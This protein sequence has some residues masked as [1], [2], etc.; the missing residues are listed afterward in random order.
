MFSSKRL[1]GRRSYRYSVRF[2]CCSFFLTAAC[3]TLFSVIHFIYTAP[4]AANAYLYR[5]QIHMAM[6]NREAVI[7]HPVDV[8]NYIPSDFHVYKNETCPERF[9]EM[10][11]PVDVNMTEISLKQVESELKH[12]I[13]F[14]G[15]WKPDD[16]IPK[17]RVAFLIPF[18]NRHQHVPILLRH[19]FPHLFK[20]H[21]EF[22]IFV[23]N[24]EGDFPF[25]RA[26]LLNIGFVEIQKLKKDY[27]DCFI[28]HDVDHIPENDRIYY[29]CKDM[30]KHF[31]EQLDIHLYRLEYD[32]FFGG[33]SGVMT[34]QFEKVNGFCN[35]FWGWGG[36]DDDFYARI[37]H[38]GYN[39]SRPPN[40][41]GRYQ[42]IVKHHTQEAQ[43]L[44][45]F[46]LLHDSVERSK[47][48]GLNSLVYSKPTI[49]YEPF[50]TNISVMIKPPME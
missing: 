30:P 13:T 3:L 32:D 47:T 12:P 15:S 46:S 4:G 34:D 22:G 23:V 31:A 11:G 38:H 18:R 6:A 10:V 19:I 44:G 14:G 7:I 37:K 40:N 43:F 28:F 16:C 17:W 24:Q 25:N 20:Q 21:V 36:E 45:R 39:I 9:P 33:V 1:L 42:A 49:T 29:G 35:Q 2:I 8:K 48:D 27:Y 50:F 41:Y 5:L 26:M